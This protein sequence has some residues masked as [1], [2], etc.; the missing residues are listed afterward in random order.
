M[1]TASVQK[2]IDQETERPFADY[3][4]LAQLAAELP[5]RRN[6]K[7]TNVATIYR[8]SNAG[9]RGVILQTIQ[10]GATRCTTQEW[11]REFF[12][13]LTAARSMPPSEAVSA[14]PAPARPPLTRIRTE[15]QRRRA[16][17]AAAREL[18]RM[19]V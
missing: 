1:V 15:A 6:G 10:M 14:A 11:A 4:P 17:E 8:W 7:K 18:A 19:G 9:C 5:R 16:S 13:R 12:E 3:I 2:P